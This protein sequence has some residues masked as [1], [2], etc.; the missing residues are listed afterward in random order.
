MTASLQTVSLDEHRRE[1]SIS[2]TMLF[3]SVLYK[4]SKRMDGGRM[5]PAIERISSSLRKS[6]IGQHRCRQTLRTNQSIPSLNSSFNPIQCNALQIGHSACGAHDDGHR[7]M[8]SPV[9]YI[10]SIHSSESKALV[11]IPHASSL[12]ASISGVELGFK[13][14]PCPTPMKVF[15][16]KFCPTTKPASFSSLSANTSPS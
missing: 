14:N 2:F 3:L 11:I 1:T 9:L 12:A 7:Y 6:L 10:F 5:R 13:S 8:C 4:H 15:L 16:N